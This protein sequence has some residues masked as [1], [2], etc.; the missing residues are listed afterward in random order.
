ME[1]LSRF[2]QQGAYT[3]ENITKQDNMSYEEA[4]AQALELYNKAQSLLKTISPAL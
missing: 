1:V 2:I 4:Q 3:E